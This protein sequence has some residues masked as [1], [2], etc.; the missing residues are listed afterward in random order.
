M[1]REWE[2]RGP[3]SNKLG[4]AAHDVGGCWGVAEPTGKLKALRRPAVIKSAERC[5]I[6]R[7][8]SRS[9][10]QVLRRMHSFRKY[11]PHLSGLSS[12]TAPSSTIKGLLAL[13]FSSIFRDPFCVPS[14]QVHQLPKCT[15]HL[16]PEERNLRL[17]R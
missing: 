10:S 14:S 15:P 1:V 3:R 9:T 6:Q 7:F 16:Y 13:L 11:Q 17:S 12:H 5:F 8:L 4:N 2:E